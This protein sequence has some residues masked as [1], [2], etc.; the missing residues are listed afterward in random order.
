MTPIAKSATLMNETWSVGQIGF[1]LIYGAKMNGNDFV[2]WILRSSLHGMLSGN[3][4][5]ITVTGRKTGKKYTT[6]VN[7]FEEDGYLWVV[8]SRDRTWWKNVK[9]GAD[10]ELLLKRKP[11]H[12]FAVNETDSSVVE[13]HIRAYVRHMPQAAKPFGIRME[14]NQPNAE[15]VARAAGERLFV[16]IRIS[17]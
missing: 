8:T 11:L 3:T 12:G 13:D 4:A 16:R 2:A 6:P 10:I 14:N 5:L 9:D 7:Y 15:D 1:D 17:G